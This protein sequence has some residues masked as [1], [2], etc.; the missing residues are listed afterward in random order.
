MFS[1]RFQRPALEKILDSYSNLKF[2]YKR[3]KGSRYHPARSY[4]DLKLDSDVTVA[5]GEYLPN[6][7]LPSNGFR[8]VLEKLAPLDCHFTLRKKKNRLFHE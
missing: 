5:S 1:R 7:L 6:P 8:D 2:S 3:Q 4:R